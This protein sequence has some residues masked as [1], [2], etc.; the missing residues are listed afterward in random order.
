[1]S[2]LLQLNL[3]QKNRMVIVHPE[4]YASPCQTKREAR[5]HL[6]WKR[7]RHIT[8]LCAFSAH[9]NYPRTNNQHSSGS[10]VSDA[11]IMDAGPAAVEFCFELETDPAWLPT[12]RLLCR[13]R[14]RH[15]WRRWMRA[16]RFALR[17]ER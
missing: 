14:Q 12:E 1:M 6:P 15:P 16:P 10:S 3:M 13:K 4:G 8:K 17:A 7:S 11:A 5:T 9:I 2:T